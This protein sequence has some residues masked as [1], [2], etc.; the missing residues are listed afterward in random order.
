MVKFAAVLDIIEPCTVV[1]LLDNRKATYRCRTPL[2]QACICWITHDIAGLN[3]H[4][5]LM[6]NTLCKAL[7]LLHYSSIAPK[8]P[9]ANVNGVIRHP[10]VKQTYEQMYADAL[11]IGMVEVPY[12]KAVRGRIRYKALRVYLGQYIASNDDGKAAY[13]NEI[14][15][16]LQHID[17]PIRCTVDS[18]SEPTVHRIEPKQLFVIAES[19]GLMRFPFQKNMVLATKI[20]LIKT[21]VQQYLEITD[22]ASRSVLR[23]QFEA[24]VTRMSR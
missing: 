13:R 23:S 17:D 14:A 1:M 21:S 6:Y 22:T 15:H 4:M 5:I 7:G 18:Y 24:Y 16:I 10:I 8:A 2:I 3:A 20:P 19:I 11:T 9:T 12:T